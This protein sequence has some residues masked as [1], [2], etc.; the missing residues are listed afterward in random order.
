VSDAKRLKSLEDEKLKKALAEAM[1]DNAMLKQIA[2]KNGDARLEARGRR[3]F[4]RCV[5]GQRAAVCSALGTDRTSVRYRSRRRDDA[6]ARQRLRELAAIRR[7]VGY[8][9]LH[10]PLTRE[11][12]TMNHR[13]RLYREE[14]LQVRHRGGRKRA[15]GTRAA[16]AVPQGANQRW[17]LDLMSDAFFDGRRFL[18]QCRIVAMVAPQAAEPAAVLFD[19]VIPSRS[20][21][22]SHPR[23]SDGRG[24]A[25]S[26]GRRSSFQ[27]R[28]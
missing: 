9:R 19:F 18:R 22:R 16:I 13:K 25:S 2:T 4:A 15:T 26:P 12:I 21:P 5:C 10:L 23:A 8:R 28:A 27:S 24:R 1:L 17:S 14:R 11:G 7:R 6:D 3:S 20:G